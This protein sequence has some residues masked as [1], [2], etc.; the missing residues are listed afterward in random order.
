MRIEGVDPAIVN[1]SAA[2]PASSKRIA[3]QN[4]ATRTHR[5][6]DFW[7]I[8]EPKRPPT[9]APAKNPASAVIERGSENSGTPA[10]ANPIT[11]MLP[12]MFAVKTRPIASTL[13]ESTIPVT[14]VNSNKMRG[15]MGDM[16]V[17]VICMS[18]PSGTDVLKFVS[19]PELQVVDVAS[20]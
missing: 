19:S 1:P 7:D 6:R 10:I 2:N 16:G 13:T 12:V 11:T 3:S 8:S 18:Y 15:K 14:N 17:D 4:T 5:S 9:T 20:R